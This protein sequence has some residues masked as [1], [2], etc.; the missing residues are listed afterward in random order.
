MIRR[1]LAYLSAYRGD[2]PVRTTTLL[3]MPLEEQGQR[4]SARS[5]ARYGNVLALHIL[6]LCASGRTPTAIAAWLCCSRSRV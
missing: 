3:D 4:L 1:R 5:G 6:L 2:S